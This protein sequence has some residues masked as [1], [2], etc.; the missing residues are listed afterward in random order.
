VQSWEFRA[1][2]AL[3][4]LRLASI[5]RKLLTFAVIA[6][7]IPSLSTAW[8]SYVQNVRAL[9]EKT[10]D[11]LESTGRQAARDLDIWLKERLYELRV[12]AISYEV[13]E[14]LEALSRSGARG[15]R[16]VTR[17]TDYL[18]SVQ[19]RFQDYQRLL[20]LD[21]RGRVVA[22][23]A[24]PTTA[25]PL[26]DE[27]L[28]SLREGEPVVGD[29]EWDEAS[30]TMLFSIAVPVL[31]SGG[32]MVGAFAGRLALRAIDA[33]L[34]DLTAGTHTRVMLVLPDGT[35]LSSSSGASVDSLRARL[36]TATARRLFERSGTIM[37]YASLG[38]T[39]VVGRLHPV[40]RIAWGVVSEQA[41]AQAFRQVRRMRNLTV[42][43]VAALLVG[44]GSLGYF[45]SAIIGRPVDRLTQGAAK[46]AGGDLDV[47]VPVVGA[48]EV[49]QLTTAFNHMVGRLRAARQE[50]ERLS[51]TDG[52]TGLYNRRRLMEALAEEERRYQRH[53]RPFS[54]LMADIDHFK[55]YNDSFGHLAG[56][57]VLAR[58][59]AVLRQTTRHVDCAARYGGEEFVVMMP[60]SDVQAA[61]DVADRIRQ[62]LAGEL[63]AG[64]HVTLSIGIAE[65][66]R[67]GVTPEAVLGAADAALY[68]AKR[69]G[70]DRIVDAATTT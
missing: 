62:R 66:P 12:L 57:H 67:H 63:I 37:E 20:V 33:G 43:V 10:T 31:A 22:T 65:F 49:G 1:A 55:V 24:R 28:R 50:L 47:D 45:L 18:N 21:S 8:I 11:N 54:V 5:K 15:G 70:R 32:R 27:W 61:I 16:P 48:G 41:T 40:P 13:T 69:A 42:L 4:A 23:S 53:K 46:V 68:K 35:V 19:E 6:T 29:P 59:G 17:L 34:A 52:L 64:G 58:V 44:V 60:E 14:N 51:V 30:R 38:Q 25:S 3:D 2:R 56:D 9:T 7:L 36:D 39:E 26:T